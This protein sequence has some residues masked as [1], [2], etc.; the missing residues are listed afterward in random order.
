L[1]A[2][3]EPAP[4][5]D[6]VLAKIEVTLSKRSMLANPNKAKGGVQA[7]YPSRSFQQYLRT[8]FRCRGIGYKTPPT[9]VLP[10]NYRWFSTMTTPKNL[11][12]LQ[13]SDDLMLHLP[14]DIS[15]FLSQSQAEELINAC[16]RIYSREDYQADAGILSWLNGT[17]K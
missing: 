3:L 11:E 5:L 1:R 7:P 9:F 2:L 4:G 8:W 15:M 16:Q 12:T 10:L 17:A 13:H 6:I 14:A